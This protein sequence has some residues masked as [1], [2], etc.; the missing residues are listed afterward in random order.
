MRRA[1]NGGD[2][3]RPNVH[4]ARYLLMCFSAN[5]NISVDASAA[6]GTTIRLIPIA[7]SEN[8]GQ[9]T[10]NLD[11]QQNDNATEAREP[12]V[13]DLTT[14][15]NQCNPDTESVQSTGVGS[16]RDRNRSESSAHGAPQT[17]QQIGTNMDR[18]PWEWREPRPQPN[19]GESCRSADTVGGGTLPYIPIRIVL[20]ELDAL[21]PGLN[22]LI[23]ER[24]FIQYR[25]YD[26]ATAAAKLNWE[27]MIQEFG[28][29]ED[30]VRIVLDHVL[31][32]WQRVLEGEILGTM[33]KSKSNPKVLCTCGCEKYV[34]KKTVGRHLAGTGTYDVIIA[35]QR[36]LRQQHIQKR[37]SD[38]HQPSLHATSTRGLAAPSSYSSASGDIDM[39]GDAVM[40]QD[41]NV[42]DYETVESPAP[43]HFR[44]HINTL[45]SD[46]EADSDSDDLGEDGD[47]S[48]ADEDSDEDAFDP[49][50]DEPSTAPW[51]EG[52]SAEE[53]L[54]E[55]FEKEVAKRGHRLS[56]DDLD[57]IRAHN[58]NVDTLLG[59]HHM[60]N[61]HE[62]FPN[63]RAYLPPISVALA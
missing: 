40:D 30:D 16:R 26:L 59:S 52:L 53:I 50:A 61:F 17:N 21:H 19:G 12:V 56:E 54:A 55:G 42:S 37:H 5:I 18:P 43:V 20:E 7:G 58:Y 45:S 38:Q 32:M 28:M 4:N 47:A 23:H 24:A 10:V 41:E 27:F 44:Q 15:R 36:L 39:D 25:L 1:S 35:Q 60:K 51:L 22:A 48:G 63:Y 46:E 49:P 57:C 62:H 6:I 14:T 33:P 2:L 3:T 31:T 34:S 11:S 8:P 13:I 9:A 29:R